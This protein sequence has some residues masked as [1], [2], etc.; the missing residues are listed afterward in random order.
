MEGWGSSPRSGIGLWGHKKWP[1]I[2]ES[3][4]DGLWR[5][6]TVLEG[7]R[8]HICNLTP[9]LFI[10]RFCSNFA[11][12]AYWPDDWMIYIQSPGIFSV[13]GLILRWAFRFPFS[14][15]LGDSI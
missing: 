12:I 2:G 15:L 14:P 7:P 10:N 8:G 3:A 1:W 13:Y 9:L 6:E 4:L 5:L 11:F